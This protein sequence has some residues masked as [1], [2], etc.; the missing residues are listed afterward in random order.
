MGC[1]M[2]GV[3]PEHKVW[4]RD[5]ISYNLG[6]TVREKGQK[7]MAWLLGGGGGLAWWSSEQKKGAG[8]VKESLKTGSQF[9][10]CQL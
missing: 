7:G 10:S 1:H 8:K 9:D 2:W 6:D 5:G 3:P 4:Q